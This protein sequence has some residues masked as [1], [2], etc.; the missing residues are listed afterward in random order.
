MQVHPTIE[1]VGKV[2][3]HLYITTS[4]ATRYRGVT[5]VSAHAG[6]NKEAR[7]RNVLRHAPQVETPW[8]PSSKE[9]EEL[10]STTN[11]RDRI[12]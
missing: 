4:E 7:D 10:A 8:M 3:I 2:V 11:D 9:L 6:T 5:G 12:P 1:R